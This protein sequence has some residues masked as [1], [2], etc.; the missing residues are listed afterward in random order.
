M[1][2]DKWNEEKIET[3]LREMPTISDHRSKED[4]LA[5]LKKDPR[6]NE[7]PQPKKKRM[8]AKWQQILVAV[9]AI[10]LLSILVPT[11]L[12]PSN[13]VSMDKAEP[14]DNA[15]PAPASLEEN[16]ESTESSQDMATFSKALPTAPHYAVYPSDVA[17]QKAFHI[18]LATNQATVVPVTFLIPN[19]LVESD[20]G[21]IQPD[22]VA[23][24]NMYAGKLDEESLGFTEYHPFNAVI[25][26]NEKQV[27]MK[28][29]AYHSYDMASATLEMLNQAVQDTFYGFDE[30]K[31]LREDGSP[32]VFDQIGEA[33]KPIVL[34]G[35]KSQ[36]AYYRFTQENGEE[37][38]SS[39]FGKSFK[40]PQ[41]ALLSMKKKPNDIYSSVVPEGVDF[42]VSEDKEVLH[43]EF[44]DVL[45][46]DSMQ[47]EE[48][49]QL[50]EGILL[51]AAS[52]DRQVQFDQ[53]MQEQW[54]DF[55]FTQ[56]LPKPIG[57][58]PK[59]LILK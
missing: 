54:Q 13:Q 31:F 47:V 5:R 45:D 44:S 37:L 36:Q 11:F 55:D 9:V 14:V 20:L 41:E 30:V 2:N 29:A 58:N 4:V 38:L 42:K 27:W 46:L 56:P 51:T 57:A 8:K 28:F 24:Y 25:S 35:S 23:L 3:T 18:G 19:E 26:S 53:I 40:S 22:A 7:E 43:V 48:A 50:I 59:F 15:D 1:S 34:K 6:V 39:N 33:S 32:I 17:K 16:S 12:N 49:M 52:F 10:L 21:T